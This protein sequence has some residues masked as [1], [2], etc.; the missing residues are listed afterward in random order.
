[1]ANME[2][3]LGDIELMLGRNGVVAAALT[4][5]RERCAAV[6]RRYLLFDSQRAVS[7]HEVQAAVAAIL[8]GE[9]P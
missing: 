7:W 9:T 4:R 5:E 2:R 3:T 1:M 8:R 6:V